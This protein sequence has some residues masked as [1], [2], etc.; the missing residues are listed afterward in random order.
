MRYQSPS[1]RSVLEKF[2][3][4]EIKK[5]KVVPLFPQYASASTGSVHQEVMRIVSKWQ[6]IP[7]IEF[8]NS[9]FND[10]DFINAF[11]EV[12]K[13][14]L[15]AESENTVATAYDH[16]LMSFHGL[17]ERQMHKADTA[18]HCHPENG[19]ADCCAVVDHRN[20]FC[21]RAQCFTTAR[22]I[23]ERLN[24]PR[25]KYTV[26]FQSRL[27]RAEWIKPYTNTTIVDRA[28]KGD[29]RLLVFAPAF[30]SDCLETIYEIGVE[31]DHIF[32]SVGG[33]KVQMVESL[34]DHTAWIDCLEK[35]S[36]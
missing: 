2:K 19:N 30:T 5:I 6:A 26:C 1:I 22:L 21:Y 31:Y 8:I 29:K 23:A 28:S 4:A 13:K 35:L 17:P 10:A 3:T 33:E 11:A 36:R 27:G 15:S 7:E 16:I 20:A 34:N 18:G 24:I 12:G 32:K 25:E 14:Y 9:Y